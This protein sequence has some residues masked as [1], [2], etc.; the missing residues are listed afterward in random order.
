MQLSYVVAGGGN[1]SGIVCDMAPASGFCLSILFLL[2]DAALVD[3]FNFTLASWVRSYSNRTAV[4][5]G[6]CPC[7]ASLV[8][9]RASCCC[10]SAQ[11]SS[12]PQV[13][14][15]GLPLIAE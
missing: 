6:L 7:R 12:T 14:A 13:Q 4:K 11:D 5:C 8:E 15:N 9:Q 3:G 2:Q 10:S 1:T